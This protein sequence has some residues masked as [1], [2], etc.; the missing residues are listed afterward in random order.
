MSSVDR[1]GAQNPPKVIKIIKNWHHEWRFKEKK[2]KNMYKLIFVKLIF[3]RNIDIC[4]NFPRRLESEWPEIPRNGHKSSSGLHGL[5]LDG[6]FCWKTP[7]INPRFS[8]T[9]FNFIYFIND[10]IRTFGT[11]LWYKLKI[12]I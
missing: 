2:N 11:K 3:V 6:P 7:N 12:N 10:K 5:S 9:Y 1:V 4:V 8:S